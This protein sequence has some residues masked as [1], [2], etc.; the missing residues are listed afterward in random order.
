MKQL[1]MDWGGPVRPIFRIL[2]GLLS[3]LFTIG[4]VFIWMTELGSDNIFNHSFKAS[5]AMIIWGIIL[6]IVSVR[7]R[8]FKP[9]S[10]SNAIEK[11]K[12]Q[13]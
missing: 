11:R 8:L 12:S 7:G 3:V 1:E 2:A 5:I 13:D 4:A 9:K 10:V 6:A